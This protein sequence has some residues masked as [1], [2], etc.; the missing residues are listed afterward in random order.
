MNTTVVTMS[1]NTIMLDLET[2]NS[3][4]KQWEI[5]NESLNELK[6][7]E[8]SGLRYTY[9]PHRVN[10]NGDIWYI[11][12]IK[13]SYEDI[14][15]FRE[16]AKWEERFDEKAKEVE[17]LEAKIKELTELLNKPKED[18][19]NNVEKGKPWYKFW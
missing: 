11:D 1:P 6:S 15:M 13:G 19:L 10:H 17:Q 18:T 7:G 3:L 9:F 8:T 2:Y 16:S 12:V 14:K 5:I 4:T